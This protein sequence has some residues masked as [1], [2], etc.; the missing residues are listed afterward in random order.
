MLVWWTLS[1]LNVFVVTATAATVNGGGDNVVFMDCME[2]TDVSNESTAA[3]DQRIVE[4]SETPERIAV[5]RQ[6]GGNNFR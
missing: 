2:P 3:V 6:V 1:L 4:T 5:E